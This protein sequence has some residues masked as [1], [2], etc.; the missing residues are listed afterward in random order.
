[1]QINGARNGRGPIQGGGNIEFG[2]KSFVERSLGSF[3]FNAN[4]GPNAN[5]LI[6]YVNTY[7]PRSWTCLHVGML[8][9][10]YAV[11]FNAD[12]QFYSRRCAKLVSKLK[13]CDFIGYL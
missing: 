9:N 12:M 11:V 7:D 4:V 3:V 2:G 8:R 5:Q 6:E 10:L 1:V 13:L